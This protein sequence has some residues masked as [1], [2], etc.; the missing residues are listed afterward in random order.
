MEEHPSPE[1]KGEGWAVTRHPSC[2]VHML[3]MGGWA[4]YCV[5]WAIAFQGLDLLVCRAVESASCWERGTWGEH[6]RVPRGADVAGALVSSFHACACVL[7]EGFSWGSAHSR[8]LFTQ[9][10]FLHDMR[11]CLAAGDVLFTCHHAL[12]LLIFAEVLWRASPAC[13]AVAA[14]VLLIEAST[15]LL[16]VWRALRSV[17]HPLHR[18]SFAWFAL[19]FW[20]VRG[21][22]LIV[23][24]CW[25]WAQP[26]CEPS[27]TELAGTS[28]L[29]GLNAFW[30]IHIGRVWRSYFGCAFE[31]KRCVT[32]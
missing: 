14:R 6:E 13:E 31:V 18:L 1:K 29:Y 10:Y 11:K 12:P 30:C 15:P 7:T 28:V 32:S 21:G 20:F 2:A 17:Q 3:L 5:A 23:Y 19:V 27:W 22:G 16:Y 8:L 25:A 4:A 26:L 9:G 24:V